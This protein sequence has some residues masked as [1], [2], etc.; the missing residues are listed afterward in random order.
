ME[1]L[2]TVAYLVAL[3]SNPSPIIDIRQLEK[4][5]LFKR[6]RSEG[7]AKAKQPGKKRVISPCWS[8]ARLISAR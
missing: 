4:P 2:F 3:R 1:Q 6:K 8:A 5:L 7:A